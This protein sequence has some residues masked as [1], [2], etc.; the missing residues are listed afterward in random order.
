MGIFSSGA[1]YGADLITASSVSTPRRCITQAFVLF[2]PL[3]ANGDCTSIASFCAGPG[4]PSFI[5]GICALELSFCAVYP[6]IV[7]VR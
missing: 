6:A 2:S 5:V 4:E 7:S 1:A 3:Y